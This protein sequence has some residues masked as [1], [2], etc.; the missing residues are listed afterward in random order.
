VLDTKET[1]TEKT[2]ISATGRAAIV[3]T[4]ALVAALAWSFRSSFFYLAQFWIKDS[5][6]SYGWLIV[7][8]ALV[9][10]WQRRQALAEITPRANIWGFVALAA[11]LALRAYLYEQ[12]E[13]WIEAALIPMVVAALFLAVGGWS[14]LRWSLPAAIYLFFMIPLPPRFNDLLASPLQTVA[15]LGSVQVLRVLRLPALSEGNVIYIGTQHLEVAEACRGLSMLLSFAALITLMVIFVGRPIWERVLL[16]LS[17]IPIALF[18]NIIRISVTAIAQWYYNREMH[19]VH[20][21]AGL[22]MMVLALGLVVLELKVMSWVVV[23]ERDRGPAL[24]RAAYGT[25]PGSR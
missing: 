21:W 11:L 16:V 25:S 13:Q 6:Y 14:V 1:L 4:V 7:P 8:F 3:A 19:T 10:F 20:D 17:I 15:T 12:N 23:E 18:C 9:I 22:A 2:P 5:N 24:L